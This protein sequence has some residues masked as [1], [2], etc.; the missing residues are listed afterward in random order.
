VIRVAILG[1][2]GSIGRSALE[3]MARHR[4][5][6]EVVALAA[7]RRAEELTAQVRQFKPA[8]AVLCHDAVQLPETDALTEWASGRSALLDVCEDPDVDV[9]LNALVGAVG[10]EPTL[11]ALR[12]GHRLALA[13]KESLVAGGRLVMDAAA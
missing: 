10:L 4:D 12:S 2:T 5:R 6:F 1:S 3:V 9:V 11:R 13:N 8:R 7:N